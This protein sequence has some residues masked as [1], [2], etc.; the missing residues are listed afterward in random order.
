M[1]GDITRFT[2]DPKKH[3]SSVRMQQGRV[4]LDADWNEKEDIRLHHERT[5]VRDVFGLCGGPIDNAGFQIIYDREKGD[6]L[7]GKGRY[8]VDG[9][10]CENEDKIHYM[11]QPDYWPEKPSKDLSEGFY[12]AYLDVWERHITAVED[13]DIREDALGGPDTTTRTKTVWQ[14]MIVRQSRSENI[15]EEDIDP[16]AKNVWS[17]ISSWRSA[18]MAARIKIL[19]GSEDSCV[20][21][22]K[23]GYGDLENHLYRIEVHDGGKVG[24]AT[25]KWSRDNGSIVRA[26]ERIEGNT[27]TIRD[28]ER[29]VGQIFGQGQFVEITDD[30]RE[31]MGQK[32]IFAR[33]DEVIGLNLVLEELEDVEFSK[34]F[35][36]NQKPKVRLWDSGPISTSSD[37][38]WI[39]IEEIVDDNTIKIHNTGRKLL[40]NFA[41]GQFVEVTNNIHEM[42]GD[43]ISAQVK[44]LEESLDGITLTLT[45][46][47]GDLKINQRSF[48]LSYEPKVHHWNPEDEWIELEKGIE[49]SF[50]KKEDDYKAGEYWQ[51]PARAIT[52]RIEWPCDEEGKPEFVQRLGIEHH[53]A[54]L[55]I[56]RRDESGWEVEE[57]RLLFSAIPNMV[58]MFYVG[59][60]G[61][62]AM[63]GRE[64]PIPFQ[65]RVAAG[66]LSI[67]GVG[68]RFEMERG[69]GELCQQ[70]GGEGDRE[71]IVETDSEGIAQC[72]CKL[73]CESVLV[74]VTMTRLLQESETRFSLPA[75]WFNAS[76]CVAGQVAYLP[77]EGSAELKDAGT[78]QEAL[79]RLCQ[80]PRDSGCAVT[81]GKGGGYENLGDAIEKL[82]KEEVT[83]ISICLLPG[84]HVLEEGLELI[85][86][87]EERPKMHLCIRGCGRGSWIGLGK[88]KQIRMQG[89]AS[90]NLV[91]LEV[92]GKDAAGS[93]LAVKSVERF[94]MENC[95]IRA[96]T[97]QG[98]SGTA[99]AI[100]DGKGEVMLT[101][102]RIEGML[103]LYGG[104]PTDVEF[105]SDELDQMK[106]RVNLLSHRVNKG[107]LN[108]RGNRIE[109]IVMGD[110]MASV[111]RDMLLKQRGKPSE[112][113][114]IFRLIFLAGN[115]IREG[116]N[117]LL[118]VN[119][120]LSSNFF[121]RLGATSGSNGPEGSLARSPEREWAIASKAVYIGNMGDADVRLSS[122][123]AEIGAVANL[124]E[125]VEH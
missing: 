40:H 60:N 42:M 52:G 91:D 18:R 39:D 35:P 84:E 7:I 119:L 115:V 46:V 117:Q 105:T 65:V 1:K 59:G 37:E 96:E 10:L 103:N 71:L 94:L 82:A 109:R 124:I 76:V 97:S 111:I 19:S 12:L 22:G 26:I 5:I 54:K 108:L 47:E 51:V 21:S 118:A 72:Y 86:D 85:R 64:L 100:E 102:N 48:P 9:I 55:A 123:S 68:V 24:T 43:R 90:L 74:K 79:D 56:L 121:G 11:D 36:L 6:F 98:T 73:D 20:V 27:I 104:S 88:G 14:V 34:E 122:V 8:Y 81:V 87:L 17:E 70:P 16:R 67:P 33:V 53:Y 114:E 120:S 13:P 78:V 32:G 41:P 2:F 77:P 99:L 38:D 45:G 57:L 62:E 112:T 31:L 66:E 44:S 49:V 63:P 110:E 23:S 15:D 89:V 30:K 69:D 92:R 28:P 107:V 75:V 3:Y 58:S 106:N 83:E 4:Q 25:F 95:V 50:R 113:D 93:V 80:M 125:I 116:P 101:N 29:N 61:Q